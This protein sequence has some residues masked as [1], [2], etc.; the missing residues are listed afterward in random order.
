MSVNV[1]KQS[2]NIYIFSTG[3]QTC[4]FYSYNIPHLKMGFPSKIPQEWHKYFTLY[5]WHICVSWEG[6]SDD[7]M[8]FKWNLV[9][10]CILKNCHNNLK[11]WCP[12]Q[13]RS[14]FTFTP[15]YHISACFDLNY[16]VIS[17][18]VGKAWLRGGQTI[19][20]KRRLLYFCRFGAH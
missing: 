11:V 5:M 20:P 17:G 4:N 14:I 10:K 1:D 2:P 18:V 15:K 19:F 6:K 8:S 3:K 7:A 16:D 13:N 12:G 9:Q